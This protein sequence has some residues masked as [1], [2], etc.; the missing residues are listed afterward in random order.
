[1][2][3]FQINNKSLVILLMTTLL[4]SKMAAG[5]IQSQHSPSGSILNQQVKGDIIQKN[6]VY[7]VEQALNGTLPGVYSLLNGGHKFGLSNYQF[8]VRGKATTGSNSPLILIDG[9]DGNLALLDPNEVAS[10]TV[11]TDAVDLAWYGMRGANGVILVTTKAGKATSKFM[12]V[13]MRTGLQMPVTTARK[14]SAF[15]YATLHNE[16]NLNDGIAAIYHPDRYLNTDDPYRYPSTNLPHDFLKDQASYNEYH[17][18]A[19]GGNEIARFYTLVSYSREDGLFKLPDGFDGLRKSYSER[20]N[21]RTNLD[22]NLGNGFLLNSNIS[23]IY[24][25]RRSPWLG[26]SY[27]VAGTNNY[28]Y[29][30]LYSIPALAFPLVN[31]N[32]SLGGTA[33][34]RNN[35]LGHFRSGHRIENTRQLSAN[36]QLTK[37]LSVVLPGLSVFAGYAFE[38]YN[39]YYKGSYSTF[40]VYQ[41]ND[42][43]TYTTYG[44]EDT[45]VTVTGGQMSDYYSDVNIRAGG[46]YQQQWGDHQ[47]QATVVT[48]NYNSWISGD[49][50]P[51]QWLGTTGNLQYAWNQRYLA[52]ATA[53]YQGSNSYAYGQRFGFFPA[54]SLTWVI[55]NEEFMKS[56]SH[57]QL[58]QLR[59]SSGLTGNDRTGGE[60]FMHRQ[61]FY[62]A[63]G[64]GFGNPNGVT[65]GAYEGTLGNPDAT[66]EKAWQTNIGV[67]AG[68]LNNQL[69]LRAEYFYEKRNDILI[70]QS[71]I[72]PSLIGV[73][74]PQYNAGIIDNQGFELEMQYTQ[75]I[76]KATLQL[77]GNLLFARNKIIDIK[78]IS[79]PDN[80]SYRYRAG[81][82][83]NARFGLVADGLYQNEA[84]IADHGIISTFGPLHPGDIKYIDQNGDGII[85][86]ADFRAIGNAFPEI[87]YGLN[88]AIAAGRFDLL[89]QAEGSALFD[90]HLRPQQLSA[91]A[92][93]NRWGTA[94]TQLP[95]PRLSFASDHNAQVSTY[96]QE[97][98]GLFRLSTVDIG[99]RV[100]KTLANLVSASS[101]RCYVNLHN[102]FGTLNHREGRD[103]EAPNAGFSEYP[104][105]KSVVAGMTIQF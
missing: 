88:L 47:L 7:Q 6:A 45:K 5:N 9:V 55:S 87:I 72:T 95:Y 34:Y 15:Q 65:Q 52:S 37:D 20:Y 81:H 18:S 49:R 39:A 27:S 35:P 85:D 14:L 58:L 83:V 82:P 78:E 24:N 56:S 98:A 26:S 46:L 53:A 13:S 57:L 10:I 71:N 19:G 42:D 93:E 36:I 23:A 12:Q 92:F 96:W 86:D 8:F 94:T 66:W 11:L 104:L 33:V 105:M 30:S 73:P 97:K 3:S 44:A 32:G 101:I 22:V 54:A 1:M 102:M 68:L 29:G 90:V 16:A 41:R 64:Y 80:E 91:Y 31:P 21:F 77:G 70:D 2:K 40:A 50:P 69:T 59:G 25:D 89:L 17:F 43:E 38:N 4:F 75:Q 76:G 84:E 51:M 100:P 74:L 103:V 63:N 62:N 60:R 99:Y 79:Y 67:D 48:H 28:L 61:T